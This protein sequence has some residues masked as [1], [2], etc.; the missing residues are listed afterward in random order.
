MAERWSRLRRLLV[1]VD[2]GAFLKSVFR[3]GA[4]RR[5]LGFGGFYLNGLHDRDCG[6]ECKLADD[7]EPLMR[8]NCVQVLAS[9]SYF[10]FSS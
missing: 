9:L 5:R 4:G 10:P 2:V 7:A 6:S 1:D 8:S 3:R